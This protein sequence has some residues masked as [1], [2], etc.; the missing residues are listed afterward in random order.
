MSLYSDA[1]SIIVTKPET[2]K[3]MWADG[4]IALSHEHNYDEILR[5]LKALEATYDFDF[6][7]MNCKNCGG[8]LQQEIDNYIV[9]CPYCGS[10]YMI[11]RYQINSR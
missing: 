7:E 11:G 6:V 9:K 5:R 4:T 10:V 1:T 3:V 2:A 8:S